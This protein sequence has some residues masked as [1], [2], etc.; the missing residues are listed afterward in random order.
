MLEGQRK[1]AREVCAWAV[2]K[3]EWAKFNVHQHGLQAGKPE[4]ELDH[5]RRRKDTNVEMDLLDWKSSM[6]NKSLNRKKAKVSDKRQK[7]R[8]RNTQGDIYIYIYI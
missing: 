8:T 4:G 7:H 2:C 1:P 5:G 3:L 6:R